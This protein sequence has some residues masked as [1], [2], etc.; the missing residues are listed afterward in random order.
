MY[1]NIKDKYLPIACPACEKSLAGCR[2]ASTFDCTNPEST[3]NL[4]VRKI[5]VEVLGDFSTGYQLCDVWQGNPPCHYSCFS[6]HHQPPKGVGREKVCGGNH[7]TCNMAPTPEG[8]SK[9]EWDY[10]NYNTAA[11]L[12]Q[13]GS[14]EWYSLVADDEGK[15]WRNA[16]IT[17]V[18]NQKCQARSLDKH[19]QGAGTECFSACPQP[20][21]QS[22]ACWVECFFATVLGPD[23]DTTLKP[24]GKQTGAMDVDELATAWLGGFASSDVASGGCPPCPP[25]GPC[26]DT[27]GTG[28]DEL[29]PRARNA[30]RAHEPQMVE[31]FVR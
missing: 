31:R 3:G 30:P 16:T 29:K 14:G 18:I 10:W 9:K 19:V 11:L 28:D 25:T 13:T 17:K 20:T 27:T 6:R 26:P 15:Y 23:A 2:G 5:Q 12:G 4:V 21:N 1:F 8:F 7:D 24:P 22:S